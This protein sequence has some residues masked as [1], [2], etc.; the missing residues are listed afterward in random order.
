MRTL[1]FALMFIPSVAFA[2][3]IELQE[4]CLDM[5]GE[6]IANLK[7]CTILIKSADGAST[8]A[9]AILPATSAT[10]CQ[11]STYNTL[12]IDKLI[13]GERSVCAFC[14]TLTDKTSEVSN[15]LAH[16]FRGRSTRAPS[17]K[18]EVVN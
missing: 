14:T 4:P 11:V 13:A 15:C 3:R 8:L 1:L 12:P 17:L 6:T 18:I 5:A 16:T 2:D 10:G 9:E 7:S